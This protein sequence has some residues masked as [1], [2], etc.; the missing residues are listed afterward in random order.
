MNELPNSERLAA[1]Q[2]NVDKLNSCPRHEFNPAI[3]GIEQG[4]GA[5]FGQKIECKRCN[6]KADLLYVNAYI[7]GYEAAGKDGNDI[8][9]GW[10]PKELKRRFFKGDDE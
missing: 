6:G 5:M 2:A 10:K 9:P 3:P 8:L 1:I 7:R 4:V